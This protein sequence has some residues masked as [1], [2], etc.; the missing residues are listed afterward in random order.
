MSRASLTA[1]TAETARRAA[2]RAKLAE[3]LER[4]LAFNEYDDVCDVVNL[5][6]RHYVESLIVD[7][8]RQLKE[9]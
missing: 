2:I 3:T 7:F 4:T 9:K 1:T 8:I 6:D 5:S